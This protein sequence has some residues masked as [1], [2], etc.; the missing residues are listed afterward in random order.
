MAKKVRHTYIH[1]HTQ[2]PKTP[3]PP[4]IIHLVYFVHQVYKPLPSRREVLGK[5]SEEVVSEG[6][7]AHS[8]S[9][10]RQ[11]DRQTTACCR[12][13]TGHYRVTPAGSQWTDGSRHSSAI[14][15][16]NK[17]R[18]F[19]KQ[20]FLHS[21]TA[22]NMRDFKSLQDPGRKFLVQEL[23]QVWVG[24]PGVPLEGS[25]GHYRHIPFLCSSFHTH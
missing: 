23:I 17:H 4:E 14:K 12:I 24:R 18:A 13:C 22:A 25:T 16:Y 5:C 8:C 19:V 3:S 2:N 21:A 7:F 6:E 1:T 20:S 15:S 10:E 9:W 11:T